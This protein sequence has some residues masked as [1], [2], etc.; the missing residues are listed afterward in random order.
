MEA[1]KTKK[2]LVEEGK[3]AN[4]ALDPDTQRMSEMISLILGA[5]FGVQGA[6]TPKYG[7]DAAETPSKVK[8]GASEEEVDPLTAQSKEIETGLETLYDELVVKIKEVAVP[9]SS[10]ES[11]EQMRAGAVQFLRQCNATL[12]AARLL[13]EDVKKL[14]EQNNQQLQSIDKAKKDLEK[15]SEAYRSMTTGGEK[16]VA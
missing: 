5:E 7:S 13:I 16:N 1:F 10:V 2:E 8:K 15:R 4:L 6:L 9:G 12:E 11:S 14:I 3:K